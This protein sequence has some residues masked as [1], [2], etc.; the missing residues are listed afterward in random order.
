MPP[1]IIIRHKKE[2]LKKCSLRGLEQRNDMQFYSY[3]L[4][5]PIAAEGYIIL[6]LDA[7]LPLTAEDRGRGLLLIDATWRYAHQMIA[8][9]HLG[10]S[11][12]FRRLPSGARTAYPRRQQDCRE[13]NQGLAS[14]EALFIAY[15]I[16]GKET[17]GLLDSYY[18]KESFLEKNREL[19][20][21]QNL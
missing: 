12:L 10:D 8:C 16:L 11:S 17:D 2:N 15:T 1:T 20:L 5:S 19:P 3:P 18:W 7:T 13:P 6:T 14:I 21:F 9:S 4:S